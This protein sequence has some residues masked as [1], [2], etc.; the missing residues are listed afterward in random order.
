MIEGDLNPRS[1]SDP[2][3]RRINREHSRLLATALPYATIVLG[4]IL[5]TL[6]ISVSVP[7]VPPLGFLILIGW[8]LMRPGLLPS[9]AGL[10]LGAID[11]LFSG[12]PFGSAILLWSL[13]MLAIEWFEARFPWRGFAQ[14]WVAAILAITAYIVLAMFVSG[15]DLTPSMVI[16]IIPQ[17]LL[18]ILLYPMIAAMVSSLDRLR[19]MRIRE[20]R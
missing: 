18:S 10:P 13:T 7:F 12:Q 9:W 5:P 8:R 3:G 17:L 11:D 1:R 20:I 2:Y 15:A 19:L 14:D 16:A 4:S 6:F